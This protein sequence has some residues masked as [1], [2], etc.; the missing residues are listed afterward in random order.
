MEV[1]LTRGLI[2]FARSLP[3][4]AGFRIFSTIGA[5]AGLVLRRDRQRAVDNLEIAFP[6]MT[7]TVR[8]AMTRAMFKTLGRNAFEFLNLK[9]STRERLATLVERVEGREHLEKALNTDGGVIAVT[10]HI[11]C[12]ELMGG[13]FAT[14]GFEVNV[15]GR[16]LWE[17]RLNRELVRIRES[18][19]LRTIDR[20]G[21]GKQILRILRAG[22]IVAILI[23]Q[24]TRVSGVYVPFFSR[25]A[26][27]PVAV[28]KLALKTGATILP[29]AIYMTERGKHVIRILPAIED[30][31]RGE[32]A[33]RKAE[34][35]TEHCSR[36]VED[37]IRY[38]PKQWVWFHRRWRDP[39]GADVS[40]AL[41]G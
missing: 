38:D 22:G 6:G 10:G 35:I 2:R 9:G 21:G 5:A 26:H 12:W 41:A 3:R 13:Y 39:E 18:V 28:A 37:L 36:A 34:I 17:P 32:N 33:D 40:H 24:H 1:A 11:G 31:P 8:Q 29:I 19:G 27:T 14:Q 7:L 15:V 20:D 25:P 4:E 23:D 30:P 16:E